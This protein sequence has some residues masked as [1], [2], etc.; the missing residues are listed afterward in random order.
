MGKLTDIKKTKKRSEF[1]RLTDIL[2]INAVYNLIF[3]ERS[4]GKS[5][6]V[7]EYCLT[8]YVKNGYQ[9][10]VIRRMKS[11][12]SRALA[13]LYLADIPVAEITNGKQNVSYSQAGKIF[14]AYQDD[15]GK[16]K[17][18]ECCGYFRALSEAQ[19][20]SS[21]AYN[22]VKNI[23]LEEFISLDG[24]YIPNEIMLYKHLISTIAR[25]REFKAFLI[26]NSISRLS[27]YWREFGIQNIEK[28]I[29]GTIDVYEQPGE[30]GETFKIAC[31]YCANS[32]SR[33][34]FFFGAGTKMTNEGK[35][36][37]GEYP[38]ITLEMLENAVTVY[39]FVVEHNTTRF[40]CEVRQGTDNSIF[41]FVTPKTTPPKDYTLVYTNAVSNNPYY[42]RGLI[43][44]TPRERTLLYLINNRAF[45][46]DNLTGTEF[47]EVIKKLKTLSY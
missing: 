27:P 4:N 12:I 38:H 37:T 1:Y 22:N 31:E 6:A 32:T 5:Y 9:F 8:D 14:I 15:D 28:Q 17:D 43:P 26:A 41:L 39:Q 13:D 29:V 25:K 45:F 11:D 23:V 36:L 34:K 33:A 46:P 20:Y 10:V 24:T 44:Q 42:R 40:L 7:K 18:V 30:D 16:R 35:W 3:G 2:K 19:R 47:F 21:G